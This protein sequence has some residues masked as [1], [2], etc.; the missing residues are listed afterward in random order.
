MLY[1]ETLQSST[2]THCNRMCQHIVIICVDTLLSS[3][4]ICFDGWIPS[5]STHCYHLPRHIAIA[6]STHCRRL[7]R[8]IAAVCV[9]TLLPSASTD[10]YLLCQHIAII[11][12]DTLPPS[13]STHCH[14]LR[15]HIAT[16]LVDSLISSMLTDCGHL[17]RYIAIAASTHYRRVRR[18]IT[19]VC[20]DT[21]PQSASTHCH[22]LC[23]LF[24]IVCVYQ[25]VTCG[26][27]MHHPQA[28]ILI[29]VD[30]WSQCV[31]GGR[32]KHGVG[33]CHTP[34]HP[35]LFTALEARP[36]ISLLLLL[37]GLNR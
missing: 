32:L 33:G 5:I 7:R 20:V 28:N 35:P 10:G 17:L 18:H 34:P 30:N 23:R 9:E 37:K 4:I 12:I 36:I 16:I 26:R 14:H 29:C 27:L 15:R 31:D 1:I 25:L 3:A 24:C 6:A 13:A 21:L 8:H 19:T 2:P 22:R 11:C